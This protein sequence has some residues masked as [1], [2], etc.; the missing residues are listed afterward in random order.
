MK[1]VIQITWEAQTL[2][3]FAIVWFCWVNLRIARAQSHL[4]LISYCFYHVLRCS[5]QVRPFLSALDDISVHEGGCPPAYTCEF[6][7]DGDYC[8]FEVALEGKLNSKF[9]WKQQ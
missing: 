1:S 4:K 8:G 2:I 7:D 5:S 9:D 3:R 6:D